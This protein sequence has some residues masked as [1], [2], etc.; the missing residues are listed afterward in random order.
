MSSV[1]TPLS[2]PPALLVHAD[3]S[4]HPAKRVAA[5]ARLGKDGL[6]TLHSPQPVG[7][8]TAFLPGIKGELP[9]EGWAL[10]GFDF[11]IG[12]PHAYARR[13]GITDFLSQLPALGQGEWRDF[14]N[15]AETPQEIRLSRPFYPARPGRA[16]RGHLVSGLGLE[17]FEALFREC[18]KRQPGRRAACPL[19]WT[20]GAQQVGKA[21]ICG[22][23]DVLFPGLI[24]PALDLAIWPFGGR[25]EE[26]AQSGILVIA[27][28]Y[29]AEYYPRLD[30]R[31]RPI[32]KRLAG[33]RREWARRV[34]AE[35]NLPEMRFAT[36]LE[37][38]FL[39]GFISE[40]SG[41]DA[42]DAFVGL[43]G[44]LALVMGRIKHHEPVEP[45]VRNIEGWILGMDDAHV[46]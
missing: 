3:W 14:Y 39:D 20:L 40:P 38:N 4:K 11:P 5:R 36:D 17:A 26:L 24:D 28:T 1:Q 13:A 35:G 37:D 19:F 25:L 45:W 23:R 32:R 18:E 43:L 33:E 16:R 8:L 15:P 31:H 6:Y 44:M 27:E 41:E 42:F 10:I 9:P 7:D 29:P 2:S 46:V 22:W 34:F 30:P 21:A 12:L